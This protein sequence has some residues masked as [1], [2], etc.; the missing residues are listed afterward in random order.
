MRRFALLCALVGL[1]QFLLPPKAG[2]GTPEA[3]SDSAG[4]MAPVRA[5]A[6]QAPSAATVGNITVYTDRNVFNG[7]FPGLPIED[8]EEGDAPP[9]DFLVCDAP[10]DS[11]GSASC[12]FAPGDILGGVSFTDNPG[13]DSGSLILLGVGASLNPSQALIANTFAD[14]FDASLRPAA[15]A[16]DNQVFYYEIDFVEVSRQSAAR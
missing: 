10:L 4:R 15:R 7:A 2:A 3:F 9:G 11:S 5:R 6:R 1:A 8:F 13:P 12:G 14:A 16:G